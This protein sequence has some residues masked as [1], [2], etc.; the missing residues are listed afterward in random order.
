[1]YYTQ[2]TNNHNYHNNFIYCEQLSNLTDECTIYIPDARLSYFY[3][4]VGN[5]S[6]VGTHTECGFYDGIVP[7]A[8]RA[9]ISCPP[10]LVGR[11]VSIQ[12]SQKS[13]FYYGRYL[14]LCEV[15]VTG[16]YLEGMIIIF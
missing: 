7:Q 11:Y 12:Q 2:G 3:V 10:N 14:T 4:R 1:M 16:Y 13:I 8:G 5:E 15:V 9:T 6:A